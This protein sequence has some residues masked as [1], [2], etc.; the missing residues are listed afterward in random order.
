MSFS[1]GLAKPV[2]PSR[3]CSRAGF[4]QLYKR[5]KPWMSEEDI[6]KGRRWGPEIAKKLETSKVGIICVTPYNVSAPWLNFEA[7]AISKAVTEARVCAFLHGLKP[8]DVAGPLSQFQA[9]VAEQEDVK[10]LLMSLND[11]M[12]QSKLTAEQLHRAFE[13]W[14]PELRKDLTQIEVDPDKPPPRSE[15]GSLNSSRRRARLR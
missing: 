2:M 1:V 8:A 4:R 9:T 10:R 7:G 13:L 12:D 15:R 6:G 11:A 5:S 14:W 3:R